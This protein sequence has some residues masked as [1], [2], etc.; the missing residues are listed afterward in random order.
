M[1]REDRLL[2][3]RLLA[4]LARRRTERL[5]EADFM[6]DVLGLGVDTDLIRQ[7]LRRLREVG[8]IRLGLDGEWALI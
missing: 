6:S 8:L 4:F 7:S 5:T 1:D 2:D 3:D